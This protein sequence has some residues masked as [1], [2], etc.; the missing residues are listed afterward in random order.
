MTTTLDTQPPVAPK[1]ITSS[2][3]NFISN[4]Q[5][6]M[7]T[8]IGRMV[9]E[10]FPEAA[11][12]TV[13]NMLAYVNSGFFDNTLFH[14]VIS[15]FMVQGGGY[16][17]GLVYKT[18]TYGPIALE[19]SNG[20][21]NLRGTL[22]MA[23][24]SVADSATT[25]FFVNQ[26]DNTFL[27]YRSASSPGYA[28]FGK[29]V[30]GLTVVDNMVK[31]PTGN[32]GALQNVPK[33]EISIGSFT[34][35]QAGSA[36]TNKAMFAVAGLE[37]N[38]RWFY[39]Q[40]HGA[41][42]RDGSGAGFEVPVGS[43]A[44]GAIQVKQIDAANNVSTTAGV[45]TSSLTVETTAPLLL[46]FSPSDD[47]VAVAVDS[48]IELIFSE[49]VHAGSGGIL[50]K[51]ASGTV[52]E[53]YSA[54]S[55]RLTASGASLIIKPSARLE[56]GTEYKLELNAT[57]IKDLA[58]NFYAG[59]AAYNFT[60]ASG[61]KITGTSGNDTLDGA[62]GN[63][64]IDGAAGIDTV[65]YSREKSDYLLLKTASGVNL[66]A[67]AG[68]EGNDIVLNVER[69]KFLDKHIALDLTPNGNAGKALEFIGMLA[70]NKLAD[71]AVVGEIIYY[72]DRIP[73][74]LD[75]CQL[76]VGAGL[77]KAL[78][79]SGSNTALAQLVFRNVI[80]KEATAP[81]VDALVSYMDG[82]SANMSQADF[83][84]AIAGLELNQ[85]HIG[86]V[87]LQTTGVE[88]TEYFG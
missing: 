30:D 1:L 84:A 69:L 21:S 57:S 42:W 35:T 11:P 2:A 49:A 3:F 64:A 71:K 60:T 33:T 4:P 52:V 61:S 31:L 10:L 74:M 17:A 80:G 13:S 88:Y 7:Q 37:A 81:E 65:V 6:T 24:T 67:L 82:R 43:Y 47:A 45:L 78:A 23:R 36:I 77:T 63:N 73:G 58:G 15:G 16:S 41:T 55:A 44:A 59:N 8:S 62:A 86:L 53:N 32:V 87:G 39:T 5:I 75:I 29:V 50:L 72:V 79:G 48:N 40:D 18:P 28:V 76:A 85:Q 22:A 83:L 54:N 27:D 51:T 12:A 19:S 68:G 66:K 14:R 20:L 34:Q 26:V 38:A 70:F 25:Q 46:G 9:F 56:Y